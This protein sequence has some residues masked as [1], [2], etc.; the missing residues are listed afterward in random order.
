MSGR[1]TFI[2]RPNKSKATVRLFPYRST[3]I[4]QRTSALGAIG[5]ILS[6]YNQGY[7]D[8]I[9]ELPI[10]KMFFLLRYAFDD[11]APA[12]LE[13]SSRGL[14]ILLYN[15]SDEIL[16]DLT[17]D[18]SS[19]VIEPTLQIT[20]GDRYN[21]TQADLDAEFAKMNLKGNQAYQTNI[22]DDDENSVSSMNDFHLAETDLIKCL[23]RTNILQRI[24]FAWRKAE[25]FNSN[26]LSNSNLFR[27][28]YVC[29]VLNF[30]NSTTTNCIKILIRIAR[31]SS[32]AADSIIMHEE[33]MDNI[34]Q[35]FGHSPLISEGYYLCS[36][37]LYLF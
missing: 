32:E 34:L 4:Q 21:D 26:T 29:S 36:C 24:R 19:D 17:F 9:L 30:E 8:N 25:I 33:L 14:S 28:S 2:N 3:V 1:S 15:Q 13:A 35:L 27:F 18:C 6:I 20:D 22:S 7:Y 12:M 31:T 11:N 23:L 37:C 5:G 16:L 10:S